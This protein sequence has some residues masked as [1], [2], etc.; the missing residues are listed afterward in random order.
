MANK[1]LGL[2]FAVLLTAP[3][4]ADEIALNPNHPES[5][6]V[7]KGD[8]LWDISGRFLREPWLWPEIWQVNPQ[9]E[10]PHL[11]YPGDLI[12]LVYVDGKP[13]LRLQR[14]G[15]PTIKL[16]PTAREERLDRAIPTIP[17]D[18]IKQFLTQPLIVEEGE[19]EAAPYVVESADEHLIAGAG[20][21]V[22]VRGITDTTQGRYG[23]YHPG[24]ELLDPDTKELL[25]IEAI[26]LGDATVERFGDPSTLSLDRT[27]RE[28]GIGDRVKPV[29]SDEI[30]ASFL[31]H[32]PATETKGRIISVYDGV[33]QIGRYQIVTINRGAR[34]GMEVGHVLRVHQAGQEVKDTVTPSAYDKVTLPD[35]DAGL[36]MLFRIFDKVSYGLVMEATRPIHV[37]DYVTNP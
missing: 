18:A 27:T 13:Q 9:I 37:L 31:P 10:N 8:T 17:I 35:E 23:V 2:V 20:D 12:S 33:T 24:D 11:I 29:S 22:Y 32:P 30:H 21:R 7:V 4:L 15:H 1:L 19:L 16:S 6:V 5:Y 28:I 34:E 3:A 14:G 36:L 26:Y 25:G